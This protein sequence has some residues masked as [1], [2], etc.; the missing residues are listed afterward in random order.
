MTLFNRTRRAYRIFFSTDIHGSDRCFRKF[1]AAANVYEADALVLGGDI[2][3]KAI[4]PITRLDGA[5]YQA[6]F[7]GRQELFSQDELK[8]VES[9]INYN[10]FYPW[11]ASKNEVARLR[12]DAVY[13]QRVFEEVMLAQIRG[14][15][16][17]AASRLPDHIPCVITPG[18]DD[19]LVIDAVL[20]ACERV[21]S[22][23]AAVVQ[24]G[25]IW[26]ASLGNTNRTPW[27]TDRE[28]DDPELA[29][30]INRMVSPVADGRPLV[31]NFHCPPYDSG[32]DTAA[33]LDSEFRPVTKRGHIVEI[34]VGSVA[35]R[36][37]I[38]KYE[39]IAG[40]HGHIHESHGVRRIGKTMCINPGSD[41]SSGVLKGVLLDLT[42]TGRYY[43]HLL[44][45]G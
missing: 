5:R 39:P 34:P 41:Y 30:Q 20:R 25:P 26:L 42:S 35:V 16:A 23:E 29:D 45:S 22:P 7:Q 13:G 40:L 1:L 6:T 9:R 12:E 24:L 17:L 36:E 3:G 28:Y 33:Q 8:D 32:L 11:I 4:V 37:A 38:V 44:T 31:F 27:A 10:G 15:C 18:N 21:M 19:P 2:V 43:D 14:W